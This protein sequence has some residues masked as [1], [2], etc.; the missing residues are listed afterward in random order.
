[1][2]RVAARKVAQL[3]AI[4]VG[5]R[6]QVPEYQRGDPPYA[7]DGGDWVFDAGGNPVLQRVEEA[8]FVVTVPRS[9]MPAAGYPVVVLSRTGAGS[10]RRRYRR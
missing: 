9:V 8:N 7:S 5:E 6:R 10:E 2:H 3:R 1:M 4:V